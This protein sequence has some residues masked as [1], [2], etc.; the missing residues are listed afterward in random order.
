[1]LLLALAAILYRNTH[2]YEEDPPA[3]STSWLAALHGALAGAYK[4]LIGG[5]YSTVVVLAQ[6][7]LGLDLRSAIAITPLVKLPAFILVA[8]VYALSGHLDPLAALVLATG[9][10]VATPIAAHLLHGGAWSARAALVSNYYDGSGPRENSP[11]SSQAMNT[12]MGK[13]T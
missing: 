6:K 5:G 4:A 11:G 3:T 10:L 1:M 13:P 7:R 12:P 9:A 8:L 2:G